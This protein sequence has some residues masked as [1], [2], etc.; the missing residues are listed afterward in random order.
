MAVEVADA[1]AAASADAAV[2]V[3]VVVLMVVADGDGGGAGYFSGTRSSLPSS[4]SGE[5][6]QLSSS[7]KAAT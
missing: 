1:A 6:V 7:G 2:V 3:V 4:P 5:P